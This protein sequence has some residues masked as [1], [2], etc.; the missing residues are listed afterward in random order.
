MNRSA[1]MEGLRNDTVL[2][3]IPRLTARIESDSSLRVVWEGGET[4]CGPRALTVLEIF[5]QPRSV[6]EVFD[7]FGNLSKGAQDWMD[8]TGA[9]LQLYNAGILRDQHEPRLKLTP[10]GF[11]APFIHIAMLRD[12]ERTSRF[13]AAIRST[14]RPGDVVVD[15]GTGTGVL[16]VAAA[17]AGARHVYA[18]EASG[19]AD[20]AKMVFEANHLSDRITLIEGWSTQIHLP[21]PA[22]VMV[23]EVIDDE[24][25][26]ERVLE[27]TL[28]ARKRLLKPGARL[29]PGKVEVWGLPV[30]VPA[31]LLAEYMFTPENLASWRSW[32]EIDFDPLGEISRTRSAAFDV[33]PAAAR[34]WKCLGDP[35]L[36]AQIDMA[37]FSQ[38]SLDVNAV[39]VAA[40]AGKISGVMI[41]FEAEL[42][43]GNRLSTHPE[44]A[45]K[46]CHW[47]NFVQVL[48]APFSVKPGDRFAVSYRYRAAGRADRVRVQPNAE[49]TPR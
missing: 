10:S 16:A 21:E 20:M 45:S 24:P 27:I 43:P 26:G 39:G 17:R 44:R 23:S 11:D 19:I 1:Q 32:Y 7:H 29:I 8:L 30:T 13:L 42:S 36:L 37:S 9:L 2:R 48:P 6:A 35:V 25:L 46:N 22:D 28:D 33:V 4:R 14:V 31:D 40:A 49:M 41:F 47:R 12:R 38:T 15:I 34:G 3:R 5:S 18:V